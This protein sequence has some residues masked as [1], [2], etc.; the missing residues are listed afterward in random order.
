MASEAN[1]PTHDPGEVET[2]TEAWRD[3]ID[4]RVQQVLDGRVELVDEHEV[5]AQVEATLAAI[6]AA[7]ASKNS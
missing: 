7:R 1:E 5:N 3:E 6:E 2:V 4:T